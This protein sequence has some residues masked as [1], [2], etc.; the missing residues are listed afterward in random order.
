M[1]DELVSAVAA[2][3][4]DFQSV[5]LGDWEFFSAVFADFVWWLDS[6][7]L[8]RLMGTCFLNRMGKSGLE[9]ENLVFYSA[10]FT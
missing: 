7:P 8:L 6:T 2:V 4:G 1:C 9:Y 5:L 10:Q 3:V